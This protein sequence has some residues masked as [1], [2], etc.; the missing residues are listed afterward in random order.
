MAE[1]EA[2]GFRMGRRLRALSLTVLAVAALGLGGCDTVS[3]V[4]T[5]AA[6][7]K[8]PGKRLSVMELETKLEVDPE[9]AAT[10]VELPSPFDNKDW[11]QPGGSA[12]NAMYHLAAPGK[13]DKLWSADAGSG[14]SSAARLVASPVIAEGKV[15]VLDSQANVRAFDAKTGK[16]LWRQDLT[17]EDQDS[18][19]AR[20]GGVAYDNGR[21][22]VATGFGLVHALNPESGA[23]VWTTNAVVPFRASPTANGGRVFAITSDNQMICIAEENGAILWRHRGITESAGILA[24]TSPAVAGSIVIVPYSSGELFALRVENGTVLWSD[25]LT[26]TG[27]LTSLSELNDIAGRPVI[28]RDRVFAISH[29]GRLVS[30]DLRTGERVWTK[31]IPGVQTPW[32]A[33]EY[34]FLVTTDQEVIALSRR[35]GRIRWLTKLERW[36]DPEDKSEP[37]EWSGPLLVSDRLL[38]VSTTGR[39]VSV[40]PYTGKV[41]GQIELPGKTLIAPIVADGIVYILTDGGELVALR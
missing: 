17:P 27:N 2:R 10:E 41:L 21:L 22:F 8:L 6:K 11:T 29:S 20:G 14:S 26:R 35:D 12:D 37:V 4:F 30:I 38:F 24:A 36:E 18:E 16:Q 5:T 34:I 13:L 32:V 33:G 1:V 9:M 7:P 28:D 31:D 40:S 25:S 3:D 19:K 23:V 15:F 39:A